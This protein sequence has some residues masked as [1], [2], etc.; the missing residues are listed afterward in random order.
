MPNPWAILIA[1]GMI[2]SA[3]FGGYEYGLS[4]QKAIDQVAADQLKI[5]AAADLQIATEK[6]MAAEEKASTA[7]AKIEED[8]RNNEKAL[9][10]AKVASDAAVAAAGGL[11]DPGR[12]WSGCQSAIDHATT[13]ALNNGSAAASARLSDEAS[14]FLLSE[15]DRA[16]EVVV[17]LKAC[18]TDDANVRAAVE[19]AK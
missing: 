16:D 10:D 19:D 13:A 12:H 14:R 9:A 1:I 11:R 8:T 3:A 18:E 15:A 4:H 5:A 7:A 6:V 17:R 2:L